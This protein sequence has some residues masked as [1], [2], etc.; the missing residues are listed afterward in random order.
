MYSGDN[1]VTV[2]IVILILSYEGGFCKI[3]MCSVIVDMEALPVYKWMRN[4]L[5]IR[6]N[7]YCRAGRNMKCHFCECSAIE[8]TCWKFPC[9]KKKKDHQPR[10]HQLKVILNLGCL[11][12]RRHLIISFALF[13]LFWEGGFLCWALDC[14]NGSKIFNYVF[15]NYYLS[16]SEIEMFINILIFIDKFFRV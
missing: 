5:W 3:T 15:W 8:S 6:E 12:M 14:P 7:D 11:R 13:L 2:Y 4:Q 1:R 10:R 16:C 9:S